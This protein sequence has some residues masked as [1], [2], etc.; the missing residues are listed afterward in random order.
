MEIVEPE[1]A[2][3]PEYRFNRSTMGYA[4][5]TMARLGM[6]S[7][8]EAPD[9]RPEDFGLTPEDLRD[10]GGGRSPEA[11][12]A[13]TAAWRDWQAERPTG[14]PHYKIGEGND[15]RLVTPDENRAALAAFEAQ[16]DAAKAGTMAEEPRW[17]EWIDYLRRAAEHG[18]F[19]VE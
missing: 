7:H 6:L 12:A 3:D 11:L 15:G 10:P 17:D 9:P 19:R 2:G 4:K 13:Y 8:E 14:I 16:P 18:G 1:G 5:A